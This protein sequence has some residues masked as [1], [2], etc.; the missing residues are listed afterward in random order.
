MSE[1]QVTILACDRCAERTGIDDILHEAKAHWG[2]IICE[3]SVVV[4]GALHPH[5]NYKTQDLCP[6]CCKS[7]ATW[8]TGAGKERV[9]QPSAA[10]TSQDQ[11]AKRIEG[12]W[13]AL[14]E[15]DFSI[16]RAS[17]DRFGTPV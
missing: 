15:V 17:S 5:D 1:K 16:M 6:H 14:R 11:E 13:D 7:F 10:P 2:H 9:P 8:W 3:T 4:V 12:D